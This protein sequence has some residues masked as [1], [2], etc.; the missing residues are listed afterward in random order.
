LSGEVG[1]QIEIPLM[2]AKGKL[3]L[4]P[5]SIL[6]V[7]VR[8]FCRKEITNYKIKWRGLPKE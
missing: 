4:Q 8:N 7:N 6:E 1:T 3:I 5:M 2:D